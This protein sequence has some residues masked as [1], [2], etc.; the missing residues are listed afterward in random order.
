MK[1]SATAQSADFEIMTQPFSRNNFLIVIGRARTAEV[2]EVQ[3]TL[4]T[5]RIVRSELYGQSFVVMEE[6]ASGICSLRTLDVRG[7]AIET[8]QWSQC[9]NDQPFHA[10]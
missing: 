10:K 3:V 2:S 9:Q 7:S 5:G 4:D 6:G 8:L 1:P